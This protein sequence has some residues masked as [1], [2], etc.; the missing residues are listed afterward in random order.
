MTLPHIVSNYLADRGIQY[1]LLQH[2]HSESSRESAH[3]A[4]VPA[5]HLAKA[6]VLRDSQGYVMAV[7]PA[8]HWLRMKAVRDDLGRPLML[9]GEKELESLFVD[10]R[11]G[12][13]PPLGPAYGFETLVDDD[14]LALADVYFEAG[15]HEQLVHTDGEGF[16]SLLKGARHGHISHG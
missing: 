10:C 12:A 14:L 15:D 16:R 13:I 2:P 11:P 6:V 8:N 1:Q 9:C 4:H 3:K 5:D 7:V